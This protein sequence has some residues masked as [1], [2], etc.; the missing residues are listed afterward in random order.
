M[1]PEPAKNYNPHE[2]EQRI[3]TKWLEHDAFAPQ[4]RGSKERYS[5]A[6]PP[7]N[8]TGV[9]H[10]GHGLNAV[11]QDI[12]VRYERMQGKAA[13]WLP[14]TDH[15]GIA[16][17]HIVEKRL[18]ERGQSRSELGREAFTQETWNVKEQHHAIISA[19]LQ[20][21]GASVDWQRERFTMDEGLS[22]AVREV[23]VRLYEEGLIYRGEYLINWCPSCR[24]ALADDEVEHEAENANLYELLYPFAE[25]GG[26]QTPDT[27]QSPKNSRESTKE[28][29]KSPKEDLRHSQSASGIV[30]A[31]TRP[32][33]LFGDQAVAVHPEDPRYAHLIGKEVW[34]PLSGR[35]V[36][37]IADRFCD[38][39]FGSGAVK[40]TP[41][42][43][44]NDY[45]VAMR[46][47]L[48]PLNILLPDGTL[49][50]QVPPAFG[51]GRPPH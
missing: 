25:P 30:V 21:L 47:N 44:P 7:P 39:E 33:T 8:V 40:I 12:L 24:T 35:K 11:L 18:R 9:L 4:S 31:T 50:D 38:M 46:H 27:N 26:L 17:Q 20:R 32:E 41:A 5:I 23:F 6:I 28:N 49:N 51:G 10:M 37:I 16:T 34:L 1:N 15:A 48:P 2:F 13:L 29:P 43:D 22:R 36:P 3:Y 14:G 45:Q 42:H 19:Q